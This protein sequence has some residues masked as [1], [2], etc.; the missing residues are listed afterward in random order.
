[1][2]TPRLFDT[3]CHLDLMADAE[4]IAS[5]LDAAGLGVFDCGVDPREY[6]AARERSQRHAGIVTGVGLHPWWIADGRCGEAEISMLCDIATHE[7]FIGEVGLDFGRRGLPAGYEDEARAQ[8]LA[9]FERLCETIATHPLPG[10]VLS[11]HAVNSAGTV[12]DILEQHGL[13]KADGSDD[14]SSP[15]TIIF[16]W[17]SGTSD[18][19]TRARHSGCYFSINERM[20]AIKRG[21][22]YAKQIRE[23]L[24][25]VET[26]HPC[27]P[28]NDCSADDLRGSLERALRML[29]EIHRLD[30]PSLAEVTTANAKSLFCF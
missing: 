17:F 4:S 22:E 9:A 28:D 23:N 8:Q 1:M 6:E 27:S 11:I 26:D 21:R 5:Q 19:F 3:H 2:Q 13:L 25:L 7:R 16:H 24:L 30:A 20:L 18:D 12:L 14:E 10:R 29:A 15:T